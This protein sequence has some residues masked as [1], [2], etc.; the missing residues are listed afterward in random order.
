MTLPSDDDD[1]TVIRPVGASPALPPAPPAGPAAAPQDGGSNLPIGTYL[2]EFELTGV[3]GEGGFGIVYLAWDHSLERRVALKEYMPSSLAMRVG[4]TQV[5]VKSQ[6]HQDTFAAGMKS[7]INEAKLLAQ[8]DHPSLVKVYRFWEA[9]GTAYMVMPFYE[10]ITL[11]DWLRDHGAAPDEAWLMNLLA[12]L[13]EALAVIHRENCFHRDIAPDNVILLAGSERPLLLDFGAARR[14]IGDMTQALTVIL[15]PGYAPVEQYAESPDLK[16]GPWTD[17]YALAASIYYAITGGT[18]PPSVSRIVTD[19]Y[20]PIAQ[21]HA[22]QYS[23]TFLTAIDKALGVLPDQRTPS[24]D[25][26]RADLGLAEAGSFGAAVTLMPSSP[27]PSRAGSSSAPAPA[28]A[29]RGMGLWVGAG[30]AGLAV[31]GTVGYLSL[32]RSPAPA[33]APTAAAS[34]APAEPVATPAPPPLSVASAPEPAPV[35]A[36]PAPVAQPGLDIGAEFDRVLREAP[37]DFR[38][39]ASAPKTTLKIDRDDL[40]FGLRATQNGF[41]TVLALGPDNSLIRLLPNSLHRSVPVV[42]GKPLRLPPGNDQIP[43]GDPPGPTRLLVIV[44]PEQRDFDQW[45]GREDGGYLSLPTDAA[46]LQRLSQA[47]GAVSPLI[48]RARNCSSGSCN[49]YGAAEIRLDIVR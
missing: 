38:V 13:T 22:G 19:S 20:K 14:V 3:L 18:P 8:F 29:K 40:V 12:P 42:A 34:A 30:V 10:G 6:R 4:A 9:N 16:Q 47:A 11:K 1:R 15:K 24:I 5:Q 44:T 48:G 36:P 21:T 46:T 33:P 45:G 25:A 7:F 27:A 37:A 31:L 41:A 32:G 28:P 43:A 26:F 23:A 2:G 39:D 35:A 49:R 17:V